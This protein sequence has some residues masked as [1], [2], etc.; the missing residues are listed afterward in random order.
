MNPF[1]AV[2][3]SEPGSSENTQ[4]LQFSQP[5][6]NVPAAQ[7]KVMAFHLLFKSL[8]LVFYLFSG[9]G[10]S[11]MITF[12]VVTILS[13]LDFW[14]VK[15]VSG[16]LLVG[17]RWWNSIDEAGNSKWHFQV[18]TRERGHGDSPPC[19][20]APDIVTTAAPPMVHSQSF[21]DQRFVHP[22]DSNVWEKWVVI[23]L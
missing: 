20:H 16:R 23:F 21:E 6:N 11:Y 12:V 5:P 2:S 14:M 18:S 1:S 17:L 4:P 22:T 7:T 15:N 19:V 3:T 8:A 13:S 9:F 10:M